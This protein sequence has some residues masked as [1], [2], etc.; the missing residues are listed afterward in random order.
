MPRGACGPRFVSHASAVHATHARTRAVGHLA[1]VSSLAYRCVHSIRPTASTMMCTTGCSSPVQGNPRCCQRG[2]CAA[3]ACMSAA[4]HSRDCPGDTCSGRS[5][6]RGFTVLTDPSSELCATAQLSVVL[7]H[8]A[9]ACGVAC[10]L[11]RHRLPAAS[12]QGQVGAGNRGGSHQRQHDARHPA[13]QLAE[14]DDPGAAGE[15]SCITSHRARGRRVRCSGKW[16][17]RTGGFGR[18]GVCAHFQ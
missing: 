2:R 14:R 18:A 1:R 7:P 17:V 9:H 6:G 13:A 8:L 12:G 15:G 10:S 16:G 4:W 5:S 11:Q 3:A